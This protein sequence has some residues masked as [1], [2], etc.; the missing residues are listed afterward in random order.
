MTDNG[1]G[2][3]TIGQ[4]GGL[5]SLRDRVAAA[6]GVLTVNSRPGLG[7]TVVA[8]LPTEETSCAS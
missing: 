4:H 8:E 6:G 2:G 5:G 3:A 1:R 7:T